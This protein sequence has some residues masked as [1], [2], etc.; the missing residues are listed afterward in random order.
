MSALENKLYQ[1]II[2]RLNGE[3]LSLPSYRKGLFELVQKGIGGFIIFGGRKDEVKD[4]VSE[5][6]SASDTPLFI[7]SDIERGVGQQIEEG[8]H[9]PSQMAV[10]AA[11]N[12]DDDQDVKLL[13]N[14]ILYAA[15]EAADVGINMPLIP[16]LDVNLNPNN[17][18]I[19][20]RA[21]SDKPGDVAWYGSMYIKLI[22]NFGLLSCA[23]HFP[24]H[25]DTD[26]DSHISLPVISKSLNELMKTD[27]FPFKEAVRLGV[28]SI[29]VGHLSIPAI[30]T[31]PTTISRKMIELLR[32]KLGYEGLIM[33]DALN[34]DA[35]Q[36]LGD[37]AA[38]CVAAGYDIILHPADA[39]LTVEELERAVLSG[40]V[41]EGKID[42]AVERILKYKSKIAHRKRPAP[43]YKKHAELFEV[44]SDRAVT[45]VKDM[46]GVL[47]LADIQNTSL[48]YTFDENRHVISVLKSPF[49]KAYN[50]NEYNNKGETVVFA[51]FTSIAAWAGSSGIREEEIEVIKNII[52]K[53]GNSIVIS[54]GSPYVLKHF[55]DADMLIASYDSSGQ[56]QASVMKC[57]RGEFIFQ[58]RLP[59]EL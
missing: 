44:I 8:S 2:S 5:L 52:N 56:A 28:S 53:A 57:L 37:V 36:E 29:M 46:P 23:K 39:D 33:T 43:D 18:I 25:G 16:V 19:C 58:G 34:M 22:E 50:I 59:V 41:E 31:L 21:F 27:I 32:V 9:L 14:A 24:G 10:A 13:M 12:N 11:I 35:L 48:V 55:G 20:T 45:L 7:A 38:K 6:Q 40:E 15:A 3:E 26:I 51:L 42:M 47:P 30:D 17:P 4:L 54:F 1:L 49:P